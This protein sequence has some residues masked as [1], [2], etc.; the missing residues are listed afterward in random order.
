MDWDKKARRWANCF[1]AP[2]PLPKEAGELRD[3]GIKINLAA[4]SERAGFEMGAKWQRHQL[5]SK[6]AIERVARGI[7][8]HECACGDLNNEEY[9]EDGTEYFIDKAKA[10]ISALM[11]EG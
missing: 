6:E 7:H 3:N 8:D 4:E 2:V 10:A 9:G 11:G 5:A 1:L